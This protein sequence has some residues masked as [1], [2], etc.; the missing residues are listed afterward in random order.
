[1]NLNLKLHFDKTNNIRIS[2]FLQIL[3][4]CGY[5][6]TTYFFRVKGLIK[7]RCGEKWVLKENSACKNFLKG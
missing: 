1:M 5:N 2:L 7:I 4:N 3:V 6:T